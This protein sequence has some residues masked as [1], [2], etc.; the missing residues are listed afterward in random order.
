MNSFRMCSIALALSMVALATAQYKQTNLVSDGSIP[1]ANIDPNLTNPWGLA[2]SSG[3]PIW[4]ANNVSNTSTVYNTSGSLLKTVSV[5][6][7]PTGIVSNSSGFG[8]SHF[9]FDNLNG[10]IYGWSTGSSASELFSVAGASFTGLAEIGGNLYAADQNSNNIDEFNS[11]GLVGSFSDVTLNGSGYTPFNVQAVGNN[12]YVTYADAMT[13]G[14]YVDEFNSSGMMLRR[15]INNLG[16]LDCPWGIAV[17][18]SNFGQFSN[19]LLV[20]NNDAAGWINAFNITTGAYEG[21][22]MQNGSPISDN[23]LWG[24]AFGNGGSSGKKNVL[25]FTAGANDLNG[26]YGSIQS[27]PE[28]PAGL[29]LAA[30]ALGLCLRR[31]KPSRSA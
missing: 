22:L 5:P 24:L 17:A 4:I 2:A 26:L 15:V 25:Y 20:G 21:S 7:N 27:I 29:I 12:L 31:R 9:I 30:G 13:G 10:D 16:V 19:D 11:S 18:P 14:G 3:S 1:A 8:G 6:G 23:G 28:P